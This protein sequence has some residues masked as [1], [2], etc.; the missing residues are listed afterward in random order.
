MRISGGVLARRT[1]HAPQG[2]ATRPTADKVRQ[3]LF[4]ILAHRHPAQNVLDLFAG[5]GAVGIEAL[6]RGAQRAT[7]IERDRAALM[8]LRRNLMELALDESLAEVR[9]E[10]VF[11]FLNSHTQRGSQGFDL[12]FA[13]PPYRAAA[14]DLPRLLE[15]LGTAPRLLC[16]NAT[17]VVEYERHPRNPLVLETRY[18]ALER[19]EE[20]GYGQT[21]LAFYVA[22]CRPDALQSRGL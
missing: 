1:L 12:V 22:T 14:S 21:S 8:S 19:Q 18:G 10:D 13:D 7:F 20:R 16:E 2:L 4:N 11:T 17:V 6:S 15:F 3:A 5:T 9:A